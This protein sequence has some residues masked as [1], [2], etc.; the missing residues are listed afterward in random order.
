MRSGRLSPAFFTRPVLLADF[1]LTDSRKFVQRG[2]ARSFARVLA[3]LLCHQLRLPIAARAF[4]DEV[5]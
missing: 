2:I 4:F 3:I 5:R 1:V